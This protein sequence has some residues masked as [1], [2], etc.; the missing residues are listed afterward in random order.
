MVSNAQ[1]RSAAEYEA[2]I[3]NL[4]EE[5]DRLAVQV[6]RL[7]DDLARAA[8]AATRGEEAF[9]DELAARLIAGDAPVKIFREYRGLTVRALAERS[10]LS[11]G[12]VSGIETGKRT[13]TVAAF[14][15]LASALGVDLDMLA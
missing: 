2:V 8:Y 6:E 5:R 13:G 14:K 1:P 4:T 12:Y 9:P 10:G 11:A 3:I 15:A 7:E